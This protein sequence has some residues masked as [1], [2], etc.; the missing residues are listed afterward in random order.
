[1]MVVLGYTADEKYLQG[2]LDLFGQFDT[3]GDGVVEF[4][5][6]SALWA[7]LGGEPPIEHAHDE[8][9]KGGAHMAD[10]DLHDINADGVLSG[11]GAY[12]CYSAFQQLPP[13]SFLLTTCGAASSATL[14]TQLCLNT[15]CCLVAVTAAEISKFMKAK[16]F[17]VT[18]EYL[19]DLIDSFGEEEGDYITKVGFAD[20]CDHLKL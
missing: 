3:D 12:T 2:L 6:F 4:T 1:M 16:G 7:H 11:S 9:V 14:A 13:C 18:D 17:H 8:E 20:L 5:E 15:F 10:F 19:F